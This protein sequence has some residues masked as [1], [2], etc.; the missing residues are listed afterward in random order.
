MKSFLLIPAV[1]LVKVIALK[2]LPI[3]LF[4]HNIIFLSIK[5]V[6]GIVFAGFDSV[7][8]IVVTISVTISFLLFT[9]YKKRNYSPKKQFGEFKNNVS[10]L[11]TEK[12]GSYND[13]KL[14]N[15]RRK[16]IIN[17]GIDE[18]NLNSLFAKK[19]KK[20]GI[21]TGDFILASKIQSNAKIL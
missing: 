19:A 13:L 14:Q 2:D 18:E 6:H 7:I 17:V 21:S 9:L 4:D 5:N 3:N 1:F 16:I 12:L 10:L 15:K 8:T 20:L 11:R